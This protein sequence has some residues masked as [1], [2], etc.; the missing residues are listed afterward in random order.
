M[1]YEVTE[2]CWFIS[3]QLETFMRSGYRAFVYL[4]ST[5]ITKEMYNTNSEMVNVGKSQ[6]VELPHYREKCLIV[7][8][9]FMMHPEQE[10]HGPAY[11][12]CLEPPFNQC[13]Q[14]TEEFTH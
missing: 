12:F 8:N 2:E 6:F 4:E 14:L 1:N 11:Q 10:D 5:N 9:R 3:N 7:H 13:R